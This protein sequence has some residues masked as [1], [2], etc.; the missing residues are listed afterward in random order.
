MSDVPSLW[1]A[2]MVSQNVAATKAGGNLE[3]GMMSDALEAIT[4]RSGTLSSN[5]AT[6]A[7]IGRT[8]VLTD[9][10]NKLAVR[11]SYLNAGANVLGSLANTGIR[12]IQGGGKFFT[13]NR[14]EGRMGQLDFAAM[15]DAPANY[16]YEEGQVAPLV[17]EQDL[18]TGF[19]DRLRAVGNRTLPRRRTRR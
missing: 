18:A 6:G 10:K 8:N 12:N 16:G 19:G 1:N 15:R 4:N 9:A 11:N 14:N 17:F 2:A 3:S 7:N 5:L 13:P